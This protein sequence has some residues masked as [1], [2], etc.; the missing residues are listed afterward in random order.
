MSF[1]GRNGSPGTSSFLSAPKKQ[2]SRNQLARDPVVPVAADLPVCDDDSGAKRPE[3]LY[4]DVAGFVVVLERRIG[5]PG[6]PSLHEPHDLA[7]LS[8][9]PGA[10]LTD[11]ELPISPAVRSGTPT[12]F[13]ADALLMMAPPQSSSASSGWAM[14]TRRSSP[15]V[16]RA[17]APRPDPFG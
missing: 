3:V 1:V 9:F 4:Y 10:L 17:S 5:K 12:R 8:G 15:P 16:T 2:A 7:R 14:M 11:P 6:I 13:P